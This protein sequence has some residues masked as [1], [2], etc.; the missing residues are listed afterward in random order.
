[1]L[2]YIADDNCYCLTNYNDTLESIFIE[3]SEDAKSG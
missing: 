1:M 2:E 3:K